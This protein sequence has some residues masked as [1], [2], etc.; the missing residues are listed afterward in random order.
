[1]QSLDIEYNSLGVNI[2]YAMERTALSS[3]N[4]TPPPTIRMKAIVIANALLTEGM[5]EGKSIRIAIAKSKEWA[6]QLPKSE[7]NHEK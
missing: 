4:E 6:V 5:D 3:C 1:V 2:A 7:I